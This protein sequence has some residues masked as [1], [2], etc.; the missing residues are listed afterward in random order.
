MVMDDIT[1]IVNHL[2]SRNQLT[3]HAPHAGHVKAP[4]ISLLIADLTIEKSD[5]GR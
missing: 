1:A 5:Q 2:Q 3:R 4:E